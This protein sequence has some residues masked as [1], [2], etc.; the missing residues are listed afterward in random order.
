[1]ISIIPSLEV[2]KAVTDNNIQ[3][4]SADL[5]RQAFD[6]ATN[7]MTLADVQVLLEGLTFERIE[8]KLK[9][10]HK[11]VFQSGYRI[12]NSAKGLTPPYNTTQAIQFVAEWESKSRKVIIVTENMHDFRDICDDGIIAV[13][14]S[15]FIEKVDRAI[16]NYERRIFSNIDDSLSALFFFD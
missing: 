7:L 9:P 13:N 6:R 8:G 10:E 2:M 12:D 15:L 14:P 3:G 16:E 4:S 5:R 1:M 11:I